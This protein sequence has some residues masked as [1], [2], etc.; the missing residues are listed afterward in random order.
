ML[1]LKINM[2]YNITGPVNVGTIATETAVYGNI[3][4]PNILA[5]T[6][7]GSVLFMNS[8]TPNH[9]ASLPPDTS[10]YVLTTQGIGADPIWAPVSATRT[11]VG[12]MARKTGTQAIGAGGSPTIIT[13]WSTAAAPEFDTGALFNTATGVFTAPATGQYELNAG[14]AFTNTVNSSSRVFSVF[15]GVTEVAKRQFQPTADILITNTSS[16]SIPLSLTIGQTVTI[17][18]LMN[19]ILGSTTIL[20]TPETWFGIVQY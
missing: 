20:A 12:F 15:V 13:G 14:I 2:A 3:S 9:L 7:Q 1:T 6:Q 5:A 4:F 8:D 18:F 11:V 10:G 19:G 17:Q 16:I